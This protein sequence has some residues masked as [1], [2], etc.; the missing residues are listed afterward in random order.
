MVS[1]TRSLSPLCAN[2]PWLNWPLQGHHARSWW[3][4]FRIHRLQ[5]VYI[6]S[7]EIHLVPKH[8]CTAWTNSKP[9]KCILVSLKM[10][11]IPRAESV[12][13]ST[14][15]L[16]VP[17]D[18]TMTWLNSRLASG[19]SMSFV[20]FAGSFELGDFNMETICFTIAPFQIMFMSCMSSRLTFQFVRLMAWLSAGCMSASRNMSW[21]IMIFRPW[22][23]T[24]DVSS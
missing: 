8:H 20:E 2:G 19:F 23:W 24:A 3:S 21:P 1:L 15:A 14:F 18:T 13:P 12:L 7:I 22:C 17:P 5:E 16:M 10:C 4:N 11:S 9:S 6:L